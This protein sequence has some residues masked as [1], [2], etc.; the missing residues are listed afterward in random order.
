MIP[1]VQRAY[2]DYFGRPAS[3]FCRT[4]QA[5][6]LEIWIDPRSWNDPDSDLLR[7][8]AGHDS[9]DIFTTSVVPG[10]TTVE[11]FVDETSDTAA[12]TWTQHSNTVSL[13]L[14]RFR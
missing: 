2:S 13:K 9:V 14:T 4:G 6:A 5:R 1:N 11:T 10:A 3:A 12:A 8:L 7:A